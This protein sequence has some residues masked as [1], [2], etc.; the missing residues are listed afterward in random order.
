MGRRVVDG[1]EARGWG[2]KAPAPVAR[3]RRQ[4]AEESFILAEVVGWTLSVD[5]LKDYLQ[6]MNFF[7]RRQISQSK[8]HV[9]VSIIGPS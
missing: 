2:A 6:L 9:M 7:R 4:A 8:Q 3:A 5:R 1:E